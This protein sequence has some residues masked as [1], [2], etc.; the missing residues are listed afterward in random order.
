L[1]KPI[2]KP[3]IS[4]DE[5]QR[6]VKRASPSTFKARAMAGLASART[7]TRWLADHELWLLVALAP[8]LVLPELMPR[9]LIVVAALALLTLPWLA[10]LVARGQLTRPSPLNLPVLLLVLWLPLSLYASVDLT[11]SLPKLT[12]ILFGITICYAAI[13]S[14]H[15]RRDLWRWTG[16]LMLIGV[17]IA[18]VSLV[19]TDWSGKFPFLTSVLSRLPRLL[20]QVPHVLYKGGIHPNEVGGTMALFVPF[21]WAL[22]WE[23]LSIFVRQPHGPLVPSYPNP[24]H[25]GV[26]EHVLPSLEGKEAIPGD[27]FQVN[28]LALGSTLTLFAA[29][30]VF[31]QSRSALFGVAVAL[32]VWWAVRSRWVRLGLVVVILAGAV[33]LYYFGP[34]RIGH[35]AFDTGEA[36][37]STGTLD[38]AGRVEVWQRAVYMIQDFPYTG[39]GLNTF[40]LV[41]DTLYPLFLIGPDARIPH[42]HN[43]LLQT[44]VDLGLPSL[45]SFIAVLSTFFIMTWRSYRYSADPA[46]KALT[47][48]LGCGMLA[49]QL[50]G[51]TD[52]VALG[53]KPGVV[54]WLFLGLMAGVYHVTLSPESTR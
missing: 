20:T 10:R 28:L 26:K 40:P 25:T 35:A 2:V 5:M 3:R 49:H 11:F 29:L 16:L 24:R 19:A 12:G 21:A 22:A 33:T 7:V 13:N 14:I 4:V 51:L 46:L 41:A 47:L 8:P 31:S 32:L 6:E 34:E 52:A 30:L 39:I 45:V 15:N 36:A 44:A 37:F 27:R 53:A 9:R 48:G 23:R 54:L 42:A 50:Y 43:L 17:G 38:F 18:S 1:G